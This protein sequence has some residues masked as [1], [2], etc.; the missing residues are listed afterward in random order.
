MLQAVSIWRLTE[1]LCMCQWART[2]VF[3]EFP[4]IRSLES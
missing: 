3:E 1:R 4:N 2:F